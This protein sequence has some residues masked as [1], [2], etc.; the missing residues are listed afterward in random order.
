SSKLSFSDLI[1][2]DGGKQMSF[3]ADQLG[4]YVFDVV[5]SGE[6]GEKVAS[7][8]YE[9][10]IGAQPPE[11]EIET[12]AEAVPDTVLTEPTTEEEFM[13]DKVLT[14]LTEVVFED[15][16]NDSKEVTAR[17]ETTAEIVREEEPQAPPPPPEPIRGTRIP[18]VE[19][20]L[21]IQVSSWPT[22]EQAGR[23]ADEMVNLG[24]DA[25]VQEA[26]FEETDEFWYRVR[27]GTFTNYDAARN[28]ASEISSVI[29]MATWVDHVRTDI[30]KD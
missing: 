17:V 13:P 23:Q 14:D 12:V 27:I 4:E 19:G 6:E 2:T 10:R 22:F 3:E 25:Y 18:K 5:V 21:T 26:Y 28:A 16:A 30:Q 7:Q 20:E 15:A 1:I 11:V 29:N 24:F 9:F 8:S